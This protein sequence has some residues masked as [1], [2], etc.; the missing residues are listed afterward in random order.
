M[1]RQWG[2][3]CTNCGR[4]SPNESPCKRCGSDG[5]EV[6]CCNTCGRARVTPETDGTEYL[7]CITKNGPVELGDRCLLYFRM[8]PRRRKND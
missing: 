7:H 6:I 8:I 2:Y 1:A 4:R 3:I 5:I